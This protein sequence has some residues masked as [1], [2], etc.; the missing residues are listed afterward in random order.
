MMNTSTAPMYCISLAWFSIFIKNLCS[1]LQ[2]KV[3]K[4]V[5]LDPVFNRTGD[6]WHIFL[7]DIAS[8]LLYGYRVNGHFSP[9][10]GTCYDAKRVLI[11]P[12]AKV[13][14]CSK[15]IGKDFVVLFSFC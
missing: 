13:R 14:F 4:E 11:D 1:T 3:S 15:L 5:Q 6:I 12:Y 10:E 9:E 7:P 2:G 8:N